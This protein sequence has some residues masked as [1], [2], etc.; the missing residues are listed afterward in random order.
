MST[1]EQRELHLWCNHDYVGVL[2]EQ[3]NLWRFSY[4]PSWDG[5]D[6]APS[7]VRSQVSIIDGSS[8]R[9]VQWFFDNLL[10]E[11]TARELIAK[12]AKLPVSD[13][14]GLLTYFGAESA[15]ALTLLAGG[16]LVA[17]GDELPLPYEDLSKRIQN[18]PHTPLS[19]GASKRMSLAGAQHKLPVIYRDGQFFEPVGAMPSTH[20]L[21]P[22]HPEVKDYAHSTINEY[23]VMRLARLVGLDVPDVFLTY[24]PEPV[25]LIERFDRLE[26]GGELVR[27]HSIDAC[28][29]LSLDRNFKYSQC[30]QVALGNIIERSRQK[31][32]TRLRLF[33]WALFN[34]LV[35]NLDDHLKNLSFFPTR[36]GY[37]LTPHYDLISTA[38]YAPAGTALDQDLVWPVGNAKKL[39][40]ISADSFIEF[41]IIVGIGKS[42]A[43]RELARMA[44]TLAACSQ[45][46][47]VEIEQERVTGP[48]REGEPRLL[49][50]IHHCLISEMC[51]KAVKNL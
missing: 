47:I 20:I 23:F 44:S 41:G 21:K 26:E 34:V 7:L 28:Q 8:S 29:L 14:F 17:K 46:L 32:T 19:T 6:L 16:E 18:L 35:G 43:R 4:A 38:V 40:D 31:A 49:R 33:R 27:R 1:P 9:P 37:E 5:F 36:N 12:Q 2:R 50:Q 24:V 51:E 39:R 3:N 13:A 45:S 30:T 10:P 25:Y 22:D 48:G 42:L 15:G 11:E